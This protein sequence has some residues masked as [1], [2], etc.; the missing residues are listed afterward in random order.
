MNPKNITIDQ[1]TAMIKLIRKTNWGEAKVW[2]R[3]SFP[4]T[5]YVCREYA[6]TCTAVLASLRRLKRLDG[7]ASH[8]KA[9]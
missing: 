3:M 2:K 8:G 7:R 9:D 4:D 5:A 6:K 1:Q